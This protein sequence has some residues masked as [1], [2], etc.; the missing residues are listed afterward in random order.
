MPGG[1]VPPRPIGLSLEIIAQEIEFKT[2]VPQKTEDFI[3]GLRARRCR[4]PDDRRALTR[5]AVRHDCPRSRLER[6]GSPFDHSVREQLMLRRRD[7]NVGKAERFGGA[8]YA[9]MRACI[10]GLSIELEIDDRANAVCG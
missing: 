9:G 4:R 10:S 6:C 1:D 2:S 8:A 3:D 5:P 7:V